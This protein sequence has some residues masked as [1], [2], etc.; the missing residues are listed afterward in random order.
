MER[1]LRKTKQGTVIS[2]KMDKTA[3]VQI[4]K[5]FSHPKYS[6][7]V[8]T[9]KRFLVDDPKNEVKVGDIVEIIE[10]RPLSKT[11][12]HRVLKVIGK[13]KLRLRDLPKK[14]TKVL[15]KTGAPET[16]KESDKSTK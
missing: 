6:K 13:V 7:V 1:N 9:S 11:K 4:E 15:A 5:V 14:S 2:H 8:K 3:V 12:F 10:T 16:E